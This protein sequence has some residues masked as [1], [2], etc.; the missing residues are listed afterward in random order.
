MYFSRL[1]P[2][3]RWP[4]KKGSACSIFSAEMDASHVRRLYECDGQVFGIAVDFQ[5]KRLYLADILSKTIQ[6]LDQVG[7]YVETLH[8]LFDAPFGIT[9]LDDRLYWSYHNTSKVVSSTTTRGSSIRNEYMGAV[10]L[11]HLTVPRWNPPRSRLNPC[12]GRSCPLSGLCVLSHSS[13]NCLVPHNDTLCF[14]AEAASMRQAWEV[15]LREDKNLPQR[16]YTF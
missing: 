6:V 3:M 14:Q 4:L 13:F 1:D 8:Q 16:F 11:M 9:I 5:S 15:I 2:G 7:G 12:E 10:G